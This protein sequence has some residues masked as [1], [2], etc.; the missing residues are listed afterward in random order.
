M[1]ATLAQVLITITPVKA[2]LPAGI[3]AGVLSVV[4]TDSTGAVQPAVS[5]S[6]SEKPPFSFTTSL[7]IS[8]DGVTVSASIVESALDSN[9]TPIVFPGN[10]SAPMA[11][12][13]TEPSFNAP[14]AA[15][16]TLTPA[17]AAANPAV[18]AAVKRA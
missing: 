7:P 4:V 6:G 13:L 2:P 18:A 17:A 1:S 10:P 12:S 8:A 3:I 9:G 5:L 14:G 15:T 16:M 11:L